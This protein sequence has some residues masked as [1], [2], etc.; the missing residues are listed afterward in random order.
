MNNIGIIIDRSRNSTTITVD[1][2]VTVLCMLDEYRG[3]HNEFLDFTECCIACHR[4]AHQ[5]CVNEVRDIGIG[6][7]ESI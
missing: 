7:T 3:L 2:V 4:D 5:L 6:E 1:D